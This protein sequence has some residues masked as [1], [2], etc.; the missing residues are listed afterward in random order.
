MTESR[1]LPLFPLNTVLFP[2]MTLS[3][4]IF[5]ERYKLM[6]GECLQDTQPFGIVL[7]RSGS[8]L[9]TGAEFHPIGTTAHITQVERLSDGRLN[10]LTLGYRRFK[11]QEIRHDRP[12]LVGVVEDFPLQGVDNPV[13]KPLVSDLT[14]MLQRYL[15]IFAKLGKV[16][17]QMT[18]LPKDAETLAFL[19]AIVLRTPMKD[20]QDL[21]NAPDLLSLLKSERRMLRREAQILKLLIE[22]GLRWRD[23][24]KPF[25]AN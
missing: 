2:G 19:I 13:S 15:D 8:E 20:K 3:L 6:I 24:P 17:L 14:L 4:H 12:Y 10:I 7:I 21:L 23:D 9:R 16:D 1:E 22:N 25:S 18:E 5:E 11:V